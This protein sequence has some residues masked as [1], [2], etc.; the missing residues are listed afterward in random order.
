EGVVAD[1]DALGEAPCGRGCLHR[2]FLRGEVDAG[3][4]EPSDLGYGAVAVWKTCLGDRLG[5]EVVENREAAVDA[6]VV[7]RALRPADERDDLAVC[8]DQRQ[9]GLRVAAIDREDE[10][11]AHADT[12]RGSN[13][14]RWARPSFRSFSTS[15]ST[16]GIWPISGWASRAL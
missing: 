12:S 2:L 10:R 15:S 6:E 3:E 16:C 13:R 4:V 11:L 8:T 9:I 5:K 1:G 7:R 14:G